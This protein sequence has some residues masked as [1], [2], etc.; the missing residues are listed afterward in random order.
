MQT[1]ISPELMKTHT[2]M[3][4][5]KDQIRGWIKN[6]WHKNGAIANAN[7]ARRQEVQDDAGSRSSRS[8]F[9]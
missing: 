9:L 8:A 5:H 1:K 2:P 7:T 6:L 4:T 3:A